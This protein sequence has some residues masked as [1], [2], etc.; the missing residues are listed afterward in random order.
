MP[1]SFPFSDDFE[2]YPLG[3]HPSSWGAG[4]PWDTPPSTATVVADGPNPAS[5]QAATIGQLVAISNLGS[6]GSVSHKWSMKYGLGDLSVG[7]GVLECSL[8]VGGYSIFRV[9][10]QGDSRIFVSVLGPPAGHQNVY[11]ASSETFLHNSVWYDI[12]ANIIL[13]DSILG[14]TAQ[15]NLAINGHEEINEL[16]FTGVFSGDIP[17]GI[18]GIDKW[19]F[20]PAN[21]QGM[22]IDNISVSSPGGAISP[23]APTEPADVLQGVIE[24]VQTNPDVEAVIEQGV[25]EL[26][27]LPTPPPSII[28]SCVL[29]D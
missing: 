11:V 19:V 20:S 3:S 23:P 8:G 7:I 15:V 24:V 21:I 28:A 10:M 18:V 9:G 4:S 26:V 5:T 17:G 1:F 2:S 14:I 13:G 25:I 16:V 12:E 6:F 29:H 27:L 22:V